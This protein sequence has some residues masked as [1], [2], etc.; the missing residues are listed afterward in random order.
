MSWI[1]ESLIRDR[2]ELKH[3]PDINSDSYNNIL[4]IEKAIKEL[5]EDK[6]ITTL[7]V[8]IV[9]I[10]SEGYTFSDIE[11][12]LGISRETTSKIF[13]NTCKKIAYYLGGEFTDEGLIEHMELQYKLTP[14]QIDK[15]RKF[16][17]SK[18]KHKIA[19]KTPMETTTN[20]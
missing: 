9:N 17:H 12:K 1:I 11:T 10:I 20:E 7:E 16:M 5:L 2:W 6:L 13:I 8:Q 4:I 15:L 3:N 19:R 14:I 18:L